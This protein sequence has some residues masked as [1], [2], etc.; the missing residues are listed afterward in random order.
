MTLENTPTITTALSIGGHEF[1]PHELTSLVGVEPTRIWAQQREWIKVTHPN[2]NTIEWVYKL[3]KQR[4]WSLGEAIDEILDIVWDNKEQIRQFL[5]D[6]GL[7]MHIDCRPF[8]DA[9]VLEYIIQP[10]AM[11]KMAFFG[12]SL[13]LAVYKDEL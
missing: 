2:I 4:K 7:R 5:S 10:E 9:S 6:K 13:S 12:A 11:E 3:E 1:N 8:G